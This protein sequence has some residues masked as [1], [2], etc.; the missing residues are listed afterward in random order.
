M[1]SRITKFGTLA[2]AATLITQG[3]AQGESAFSA[4]TLG[5]EIQSVGV[6]LHLDTGYSPIASAISYD[7]LL[8]GGRLAALF[9]HAYSVGVGADVTLARQTQTAYMGV[10]TDLDPF[11]HWILHPSL[12]LLTGVAY[13]HV[14][15][16]ARRGGI[17]DYRVFLQP[18]LRLHLNLGKY[19]RLHLGA[20]YR[21]VA[22][23]E[24]NALRNETLSVAQGTLG[25]T[26]GIL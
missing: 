21:A 19:V 9:N 25:F 22:G 8:L 14:D 24:G 4:A 13:L 10:W 2:L 11:A 18:E 17:D 1:F 3:Y 5:N 15:S 26:L 16:P 12:S 23:P 7:S 20:S 6:A